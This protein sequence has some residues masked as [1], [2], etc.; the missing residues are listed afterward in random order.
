M[1]YPFSLRDLIIE[2]KKLYLVFEFLEKDLKNYIISKNDIGEQ[3]TAFEI[4]SFL[5]QLLLGIAACHSRR[6]L[7]R[8]LKPQNLLINKNGIFNCFIR[9]I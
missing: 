7:H 4:K 9:E 1:T 8:D 6:I 3:L 2:G 5:Y